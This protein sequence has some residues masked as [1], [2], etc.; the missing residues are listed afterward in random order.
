[1]KKKLLGVLSKRIPPWVILVLVIVVGGYFLVAHL[2]KVYAERNAA[3]REIAL[4][5]PE[6][7]ACKQRLL[8]FYNAW[9]R[10]RADHKGA[11]P[12]S[13]E[14]LIPKYIPDPNLL[15]CPTVARWAKKGVHFTVGTVAIGRRVYPVS[16][17]FRWLASSMNAY[18]I[19]KEGDNAPLVVCYSHEEGVYWAAYHRPPPVGAFNQAQRDRWVAPVRHTYALVIRRNGKIDTLSPDDE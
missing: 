7:D 11:E 15:V 16:Y 8:L 17:G 10:Y 3:E 2:V 14:A 4:E 9:K 1:M 19:K 6:I 5:R 12:P 18:D 13:L